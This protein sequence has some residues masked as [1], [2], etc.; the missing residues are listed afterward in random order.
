M[1]TLLK[2]R[3]AQILANVDQRAYQN[4]IGLRSV[5]NVVGLEA[6]TAVARSDLVDG[7]ADAGKV[8]QKAKSALEACIVCVGLVDQTLLRRRRRCPAARLAPGR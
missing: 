3:R 8:G 2:E 5:E 6:K 1:A 4:V 7:C